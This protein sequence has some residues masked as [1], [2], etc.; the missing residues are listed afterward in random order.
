MATSGEAADPTPVPQP[1]AGAFP[2][3]DPHPLSK[4]VSPDASEQERLPRA[5]KPKPHQRREGHRPSDITVGSLDPSSPL[6]NA[7]GVAASSRRRN[8]SPFSSGTSP[9]RLGKS[10]PRHLSPATS[11]VC[12][13]VEPVSVEPSP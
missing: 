13:A 8:S 6:R 1:T 7:G 4:S 3:S 2:T 5:L 11:K 9:R 10:S 12:F